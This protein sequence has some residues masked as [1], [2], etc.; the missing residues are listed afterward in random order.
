MYVKPSSVISPKNEIKRVMVLSDE[1]EGGA[2]IALLE[3]EEGVVLA[4][5]TNGTSAN[6]LGNPKS[7][8][9]KPLWFI[10]PENMRNGIIDNLIADNR[11]EIKYHSSRIVAQDQGKPF[12]Y[13]IGS[14]IGLASVNLIIYA[15]ARAYENGG[16]IKILKNDNALLYD[17]LLALYQG[18]YSFAVAVDHIPAY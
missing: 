7:S 14:S 15:I 1:G 3:K 18:K 2:S 13:F 4:T 5:R 17:D 8:T 12:R 16:I 11:E 6:P 9:G 10:V